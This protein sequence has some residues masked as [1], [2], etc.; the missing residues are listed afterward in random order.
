MGLLSDDSISSGCA[1][2]LY[3]LRLTADIRWGD[4]FDLLRAPRRT[5]QPMSLGQS[6]PTRPRRARL[7]LRK[8]RKGLSALAGPAIPAVP[9]SPIASARTVPRLCGRWRMDGSMGFAR[10]VLGSEAERNSQPGCRV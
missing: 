9:A 8:R 10:P 3:Q 5:L 4:E 6:A 1:I 7:R 2:E